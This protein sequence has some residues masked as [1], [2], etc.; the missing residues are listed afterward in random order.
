MN[1]ISFI[2]IM[3]LTD[4]LHFLLFM[5]ITHECPL[6]CRSIESQCKHA[7]AESILADNPFVR[8]TV[9]R[10]LIPPRPTMLD[11]TMHNL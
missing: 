4:T 11:A 6:G 2:S 7:I 5:I 3:F 10:K 8:A 9:N 1:L